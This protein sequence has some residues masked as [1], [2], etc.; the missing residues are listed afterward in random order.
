MLS[1][2]TPEEAL[3]QP[4]ARIHDYTDVGNIHRNQSYEFGDV[5]EALAN[6]AHARPLGNAPDGLL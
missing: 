2:S 6:S 1:I 3:A 4:E 5:E